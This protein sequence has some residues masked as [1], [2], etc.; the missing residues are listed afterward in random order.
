MLPSS[1]LTSPATSVAIGDVVTPCAGNG[2]ETVR[3]TLRL[4]TRRCAGCTDCARPELPPAELIPDT[5]RRVLARLQ[6]AGAFDTDD[7]PM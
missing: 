7:D 1:P 4:M 5:N 6:A 2:V 3:G